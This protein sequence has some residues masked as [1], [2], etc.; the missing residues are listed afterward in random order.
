MTGKQR[1]VVYCG[2]CLAT[3][4]ALSCLPLV[5]VLFEYRGI[6]LRYCDATLGWFAA[7]LYGSFFLYPVFIGGLSMAALLLP[8]ATTILLVKQSRGAIAA[9][10][11]FYVATTIAIA[12]LE[13]VGSPYA[14]FEI[15]PVTLQRNP[16]FLSG[17]ENACNGQ[18]F[19]AYQQSL[20]QMAGSVSY[21]KW[22]YHLGFVTQALMQNAVFVVF[23]A[24]IFFDRGKIKRSAPYL[25]DAVFYILGYA[26]FLGSIWCI[27][28][29]AHQNDM[30]LLFG[31]GSRFGG[32][33]AI[34]GIYAIVLIVF[35]VYFELGFDQ[36]AKTL[37]QIGQLLVFVSGVALTQHPYG[38]LFFGWKTSVVNLLVLFLV[39]VFV[40]AIT[41]AFFLRR[42]RP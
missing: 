35:I 5:V 36:L 12:V 20:A 22:A 7:T 2:S 27:F 23:L 16:A 18:V 28:R 33:Y 17:L 21:T 40:S 41:L 6:A 30:T 13:F 42:N 26:V 3:L 37:A 11:G 34:V 15:N 4:W 25:K 8:L 29:L 14:V 10:G 38:S 9:L 1:L 19:R 24:F 32:G 39:F 31:E